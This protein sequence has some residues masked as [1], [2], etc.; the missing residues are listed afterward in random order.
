MTITYISSF[1]ILS[2]KNFKYFEIP[3]LINFSFFIDF[4]ASFPQIKWKGIGFGIP[5]GNL[6]R[7]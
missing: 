2:F 6:G 7:P 1:K 3:L 5:L 4:E